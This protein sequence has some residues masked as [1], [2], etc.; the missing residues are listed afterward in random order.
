MVARGEVARGTTVPERAPVART[1][2]PS[3]VAEI[4][5]PVVSILGALALWE[6]ISRAGLI[7]TNDLP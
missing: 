3:R 1:I 6:V 7:S 5:V 4:L 2:R